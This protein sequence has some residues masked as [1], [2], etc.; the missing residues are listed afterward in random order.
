MSLD[1]RSKQIEDVARGMR[2]AKLLE[3]QSRWP[4]ERIEQHQQAA[5][6]ELVRHAAASSPWW[7]ERLADAAGPGPVELASLPTLDKATMMEH[8]DELVADRRLRRD[9]LLD[10]LDR[11][12]G[13]ELCLGEYR[14]MTTSGAS[15][16]KGLFVYDRDAW[17]WICAQ[18]L[19]HTATAGLKPRVPRTRLAMVGG[20]AATH[21]SRRGAATLSVGIHKLL[22]LAVTM[23][24]ERVVAALNQ[25]QPQFIFTYPSMALLL[26]GEQLEGRLGIAPNGMSTSSELRTPEMSDRI[27]EA[28]GVRPANLYATTEGAWGSTC[29]SGEHIHLYEGL[30][31]VE[32]VDEEGRPVPE[33]ERGARLLVTN[34]FNRTQPL[35]RFE[36]SDVFSF[37]PE[38]CACG[39][40]LRRLR[41]LDG[42]ADDVLRLPGFAGSVPVHP[43]QFAVVTADPD[44]REFQVV[45]SGDHLCLRVAL[46]E[47]ATAEVASARLR[48][49]VG[50]GLA[51]LGVTSPS[52][53]VEL[54]ERIERPP[55]G[56]VQMV[57]A[58]RDRAPA[59]VS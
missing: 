9:E 58:Q 42:R 26:A 51:R 16:S 52:V 1:Y 21:M 8:Y 39:R 53:E 3:H 12:E 37:E 5:L 19:N 15:G 33:G 22:P 23:P 54:C 57:V 43:L 25:F 17:R 14:P 48:E 34:L 49:R 38:P 7:R 35:I 6:K 47:G 30:S 18:F 46:R 20:G 32:N 27:E 10:Q 28:F 55:W 56:K 4:R 24:L 45:Q 36:V 11:L 40:T 13:D 41:S 50:A 31:I 44:V 59:G 2:R 29:E